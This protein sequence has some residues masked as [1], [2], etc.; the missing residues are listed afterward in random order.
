MLPAILTLG[1]T[2]P[3]LL[4]VVG[5]A[6]REQPIFVEP[7]DPAM[8]LDFYDAQVAT[9]E[10]GFSLSNCCFLSPEVLSDSL[11]KKAD[12]GFASASVVATVSDNENFDSAFVAPL[13]KPQKY[14]KIELH[15]TSNGEPTAEG[16][17][18][19][20]DANIAID[21][22][23]TNSSSPEYPYP[24]ISIL[25]QNVTATNLNSCHGSVSGQVFDTDGTASERTAILGQGNFEPLIVPMGIRGKLHAQMKTG[26][27]HQGPDA[28]CTMWVILK[29]E[30][31]SW[32]GR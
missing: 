28:D 21:L 9:P 32:S 30:K 5:F 27:A 7:A 8:T 31:G 18:V 24:W 12:D 1:L 13:T 2:V 29:L 11:E 4:F 3:L 22:S 17:F 15:A 19:A 20:H 25:A 23:F 6:P 10:P 26:T 16:G 14:V